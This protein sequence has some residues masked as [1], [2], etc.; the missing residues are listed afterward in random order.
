MQMGRFAWRWWPRSKNKSADDAELSFE[1]FDGG[2]RRQVLHARSAL[3]G[4][5]ALATMSQPAE[6]KDASELPPPKRALTGRDEAG[7]SVFK[8][9]DGTSRVVEIG[10]NPG[11][12]FYELYMTEGVPQLAGLEPDPMLEG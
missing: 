10:S 5:G 2:D 9:F 8:A 6:A 3:A 4:G 1:R 11:L 12:I 7:K